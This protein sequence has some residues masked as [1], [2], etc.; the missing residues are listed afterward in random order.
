MGIQRLMTSGCARAPGLS[1]SNGLE[2]PNLGRCRFV[3]AFCR[4]L[5]PNRVLFSQSELSLTALQTVKLSPAHIIWPFR[6]TCTTLRSSGLV[7]ACQRIHT[8]C[9]ALPLGRRAGL[10]HTPNCQRSSARSRHAEFTTQRF[11]RALKI[12]KDQGSELS[13]DVLVTSSKHQNSR[14]V[15][16]A[17]YLSPM[18]VRGQ[19]LR[20]YRR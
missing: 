5:G 8:P 19:C 6:K 7:S 17:P 3:C 1:S 15:S 10:R 11:G 2:Q 9:A 13:V 18:K 14:L 16:Q 4:P 20:S 12:G